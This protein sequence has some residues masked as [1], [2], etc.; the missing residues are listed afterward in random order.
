GGD[1]LHHYPSPGLGFDLVNNYGPTENTVVA[2]SGRVR[3]GKEQ[4][5][6]PP[7]GRP[8]ANA[9]IYLM[10]GHLRPV[11]VAI[12]G[13]LHIGGASLARGYLSDPALTA[14]KFI[15]SPFGHDPGS[16]IYR[17][18]DLARYHMDGNIEFLGRADH[19]VKI[20]GFRIE[21]GD[22]TAA[23]ARHPGVREVI[24]IAT[25]HAAG[26]KRLAAY[27][28]PSRKPAVSQMQLRGFLKEKLPDYM[29]PSSFTV[30]EQFP[31][32]NNGKIDREALAQLNNGRAR[33][34]EASTPPATQLELTIVSILE[35]VL[36]IDKIGVHDNF[37]DAGANSLLIIRVASKL[38]E[39]L[40]IEL[41]VIELFAHPTVSL[42]VSHIGQISEIGPRQEEAFLDPI[43]DRARLRQR[44]LG[45]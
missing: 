36:E 8:I 6:A 35:E 41:S 39:A 16:R 28:T 19:Q 14:S 45:W 17:T 27:W 5:A 22:V 38:R 25:Q 44:A 1:T 37:F 11:P 10:G 9:E 33:F 30:V 31:L 42:L 7:I 43:L 15:P 26:E 32:T 12:P 4:L 24:V 40:N 20:R 34:E 18:G 29:V 21:L 2:T 3:G 13:E 23:M